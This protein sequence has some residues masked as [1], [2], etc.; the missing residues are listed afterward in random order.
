MGTLHLHH[1]LL[2]TSSCRQHHH[3]LIKVDVAVLVE[4][5]VA[6]D[7]LQLA[8]LQLLPQEALHRLLQLLQADLPIAVAVELQR[9]G[10]ETAELRGQGSR[11]GRRGGPRREEVRLK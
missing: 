1:L 8:L 5:D 9:G 2:Q 4:V 6:E 7:L 11:G 3:E 10:G